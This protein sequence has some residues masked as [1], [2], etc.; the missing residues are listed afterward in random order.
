MRSPTPRFGPSPAPTTATRQPTQPAPTSQPSVTTNQSQQTVQPTAPA[1]T[2]GDALNKPNGD[3]ERKSVATGSGFGNGGTS[4]GDDT[5][6]GRG[7]S[8]YL[9]QLNTTQV[10]QKKQISQF[11]TLPFL[12]SNLTARKRL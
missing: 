4:T 7:R 10:L 9:R 8:G 1:R 5:G 6:V 11:F 2:S 3:S 12:L